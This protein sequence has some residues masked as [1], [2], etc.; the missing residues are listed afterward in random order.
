MGI[1]KDDGSVSYIIGLRKA[2]RKTIEKQ[3]G[4][5]VKVTVMERG[6]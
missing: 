2:I 6:E 1:K 5:T 3:P 4:D